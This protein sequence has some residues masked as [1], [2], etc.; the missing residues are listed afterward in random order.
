MR[1]EY[2]ERVG[3][4]TRPHELP[5]RARR[6]RINCGRGNGP[7]GTTSVCA[8]N[9][10]PA[11][12]FADDTRNYLRVRGEYPGSLRSTETSTELPPRARRILGVESEAVF[13]MGTT[14]ACAE[15]TPHAPS[16]IGLPRNYLR[17][18]GEYVIGVAYRF[19]ARELPP[20]ARRILRATRHPPP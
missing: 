18:R 2:H 3:Q 7:F 1:G 6:I 20:R 4:I 19:S 5:P 8:E 12:S 9:T 11:F 10:L 13:T 14:S 15:N 17:V 16:Q